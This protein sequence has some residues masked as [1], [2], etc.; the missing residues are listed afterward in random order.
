M[1]STTTSTSI[2]VSQQPDKVFFTPADNVVLEVLYADIHN[3]QFKGTKDGDEAPSE[4]HTAALKRLAGLNDAKHPSFQPT[5]FC[6]WDYDLNDLQNSRTVQ[7]F[8]LQRYVKWARTVVRHETDVVFLSHI[9]LY[10]TTALPSAT[11]L[12]YDFHF[13]HA[14]A[15]IVYIVWCS[16]A[17]TLMMHNHIHNNGVLSKKYAAFD[18]T[19]PY[20]LEPLMGHTWDSYYYHHVK[21]HHVE[22]NGPD[23]LSTTICYQRDSWRAFLHYEGRFLLLCWFD[24]PRYFIK[25]NKYNIAARVAVTE[26]SSYAM[27]AFLA[28]VNFRPAFFVFILPFIVLRIGLMIG[29]W[30]QHALVDD[31]DPD[32]DFRSSIT[33]ID[34]PSNR[35]CFNDGYHTSHHLN[36]LRHWRDHPNAFLTAKE[37]YSEEG[38]LVFQGIDYLEITF[39]LLTKN[40]MYLAKKLVPMGSQIGMTE[41]ELAAMLKLKTRKF[42]EK[43]IAAKF[44]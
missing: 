27:M 7:E 20:I 8:I 13:L 12:F 22:G 21:A 39:R 32:S 11:Y 18:W 31:V 26:L 38:A 17:F 36:P 41:Q 25:K 34:V 40:Y 10:F 37:R 43:E 1:T 44:K 6:A 15:H 5:I 19:F 4:Q 29:N 16:G 3:A 28:R 24:L 30:G 9:L 35:F 23:D 2:S 14:F 42:S 33:L